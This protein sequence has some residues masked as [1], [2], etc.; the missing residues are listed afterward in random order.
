MFARVLFFGNLL[1]SMAFYLQQQVLNT[2]RQAL[3]PLLATLIG[4][5]AQVCFLCG[6][7]PLCVTISSILCA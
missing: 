1:P 2:R 5:G 4:T 7:G 3:V 6:I